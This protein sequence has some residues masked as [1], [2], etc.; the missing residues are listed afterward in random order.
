MKNSIQTDVRGLVEILKETVKHDSS[1]LL[2]IEGD[3]ILIAGKV[4]RGMSAIHQD[5]AR[6]MK[7]PGKVSSGVL[8]VFFAQGHWIASGTC[9]G[10]EK[11]WR[12]FNNPND[13]VVCRLEWEQ[14]VGIRKEH[15]F[16]RFREYV[17]MV[18]GKGDAR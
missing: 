14:H 16:E 7:K 10:H 15:N 13:A 8:G 18:E 9:K 1:F 3:D 5:K 2:G 17:A 11:L 4:N 12:Y 6:Q